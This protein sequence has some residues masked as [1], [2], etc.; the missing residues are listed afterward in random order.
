MFIHL[1]VVTM[2]ASMLRFSKG[3]PPEV[4]TLE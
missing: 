4:P 1:T 2:L 3:I